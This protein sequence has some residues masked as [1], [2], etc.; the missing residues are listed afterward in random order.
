MSLMK[1]ELYEIKRDN[2]D[3]PVR[4]DGPMKDFRTRMLAVFSR[5]E[6]AKI[7][8]T[9]GDREGQ[10]DGLERYRNLSALTMSQRRAAFRNASAKQKSDLW[11]TH[12]ALYLAKHPE[13]SDAL[14]VIVLEGMSLVTP[15]LFEARSDNPDWKISVSARLKEFE[16]HILSVFST[17]EGARVFT[18]LGDPQ[19]P[20]RIPIAAG[21]N[22]STDGFAASSINPKSISAALLV[23]FSRPNLPDCSCSTS[24]DWCNTV[25]TGTGSCEHSESG[26][27]TF[28]LYPCNGQCYRYLD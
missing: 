12:L 13:L 16:N 7:F 25:C 10:D 19:P 2:P 8:A 18:I 1:P 23:E 5:D 6:A 21:W 24:S 9:L 22:T 20:T 26:C 14:R 15:E 3:W 4:V 27:G 11:R 28:W 17:E